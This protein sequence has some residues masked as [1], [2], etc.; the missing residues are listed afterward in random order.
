MTL[1]LIVFNFLPSIEV[2]QN[3][4]SNFYININSSNHS[5][6]SKY[7]MEGLEFTKSDGSK[8]SFE[9]VKGK[10]L[11]LDF[12]ATW[13]GPCRKD[14][15]IVEEIY[16]NIDDPNFEI[17]TISID[18]NFEEWNKFFK[19]NHWE[20]IN[21]YVGWKTN[22]P[23]F[24]M[25]NTFVKI[26]NETLSRVSVP[27]YFLIDKSLNISKIEDIKNKELETKIKSLLTK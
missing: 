21:I 5:D 23:L 1:I 9:E 3:L 11:L 22:H 6:S 2:P 26:K 4:N 19:N 15:P 8:F 7:F 17:I 14:H 20:G 24:E 25:V 12:W 10:V 13:C 18:K 27:Q 16:K